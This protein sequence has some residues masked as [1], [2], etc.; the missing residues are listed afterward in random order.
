MIGFVAVDKMGTFESLAKVVVV[1]G[2]VTV[3]AVA[4]TGD[5]VTGDEGLPSTK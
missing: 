4:V 2:I 1:V 5:S 3:V